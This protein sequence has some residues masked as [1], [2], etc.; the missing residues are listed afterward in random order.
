MPKRLTQEEFIEKITHT[1]G[2]RYDF[3]RAV[4][5]NFIED[6]IVRCPTHGTM[7]VK[8]YALI[9]AHWECPMCR[10]VEKAKRCYGA[11]YRKG[12]ENKRVSYL[13]WSAM[14]HRCYHNNDERDSSYSGCSVCEEWHDYENFRKWFSENY[15]EGYCLDKDLIKKGN[16]IYSPDT[17]CFL[18]PRINIMFKG[19]PTRDK[20]LPRGV[21][22]AIRSQRYRA[23]IGSMVKS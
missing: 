7:N 15:V 16:K 5:R 20:L 18:P 10:G 8:A 17:C 2:N 21:R 13:R 6:V 1:Y 9:R 19:T 4:Y 23:A 22:K 12:S 11:D 14:M 3:S